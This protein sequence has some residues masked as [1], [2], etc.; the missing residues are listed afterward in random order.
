MT[1]QNSNMLDSDFKPFSWLELDSVYIFKKDTHHSCVMRSLFSFE[2]ACLWSL[3]VSRPL[4]EMLASQ[5]LQFQ[6][7]SQ[8]S[9]L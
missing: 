5:F 8:V 7:K 4:T 1:C 2:G 9:E 3:K 6:V